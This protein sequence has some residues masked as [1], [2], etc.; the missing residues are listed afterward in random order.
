MKVEKRH[1]DTLITDSISGCCH[2]KICRLWQ[3]F[4]FI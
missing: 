4:T 1:S 2:F 3:L